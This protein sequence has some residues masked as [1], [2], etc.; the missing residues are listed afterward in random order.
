MDKYKIFKGVLI[1]IIIICFGYVAFY[2]INA[3]ISKG[4][5]DALSNITSNKVEQGNTYVQKLEVVYKGPKVLKKYE[6][7]YDKNK[8]SLYQLQKNVINYMNSL[9]HLV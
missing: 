3:Y 9:P 2:Y 7:L 6:T 5:N 4:K 8:N 1:S